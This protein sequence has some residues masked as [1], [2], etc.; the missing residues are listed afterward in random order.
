[1]PS[2]PCWLMLVRL[3]DP[4]TEGRDGSGDCEG[5]LVRDLVDRAGLEGG[6]DS[7]LEAVLGDG[8]RVH[9]RILEMVLR[10]SKSLS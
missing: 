10:L 5:V 1:M 4:G 7:G 6:L 8:L 3:R 9:S 2:L